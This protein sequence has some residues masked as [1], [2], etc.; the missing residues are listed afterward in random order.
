[1]RV[2]LRILAIATLTVLA[3]VVMRRAIA[4][5]KLCYDQEMLLWN[6]LRELDV[7]VTDAYVEPAV[8]LVSYLAFFST[9]PTCITESE[10]LFNHSGGKV[11]QML[12]PREPTS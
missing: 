7:N 9:C 3:C 2:L 11:L 5:G 4:T 1:M 6:F 10:T 8:S 12:Q